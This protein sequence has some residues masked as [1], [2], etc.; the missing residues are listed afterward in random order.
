[1]CNVTCFLLAGM[2]H[3]RDPWPRDSEGKQEICAKD[4]RVS[5]PQRTSPKTC[6]QG[7]CTKASWTVPK[8]Y[9]R[10]LRKKN[11]LK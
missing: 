2:G 4:G 1:M 6:S 11:K 9:R 3:V 10:L 5:K 7:G 8:L